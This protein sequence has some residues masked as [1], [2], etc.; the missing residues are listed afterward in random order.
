MA[1]S[2]AKPRPIY[3]VKEYM[4]NKETKLYKFGFRILPDG[5]GVY[6]QGDEVFPQH[7]IDELL[8]TNMDLTAR[9]NVDGKQNWMHKR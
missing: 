7:E 8:P 2:A 6:T 1:K 9:E 5:S 4:Y 3:T